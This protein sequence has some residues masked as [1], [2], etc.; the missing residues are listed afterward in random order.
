ML[1]CITISRDYI[2]RIERGES[3]V[4]LLKCYKIANAFGVRLYEMFQDLPE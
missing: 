1:I 2:G 3:N 4:T